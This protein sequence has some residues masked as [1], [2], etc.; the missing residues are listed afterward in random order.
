MSNPINFPNFDLKAIFNAAYQEYK[1]Q[2]YYTLQLII[3]SK[4]FKLVPNFDE[5]M[6]DYQLQ[7]E[8]TFV[9]N[10]IEFTD[11]SIDAQTSI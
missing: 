8:F 6:Q 1:N 7:K 3:G 11:P 5:I 2:D 4:W 10:T 9:D